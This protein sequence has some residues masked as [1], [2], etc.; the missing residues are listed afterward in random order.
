MAQRWMRGSMRHCSGTRRTGICVL[1]DA[2]TL[3]AVGPR[4]CGVSA[5]QHPL[6]DIGRPQVP[7][8]G[9]L[10]RPGRWVGG[11]PPYVCWLP[12]GG[13]T[14]GPGVWLPG[15]ESELHGGFD[16]ELRPYPYGGGA[17][18]RCAGRAAWGS[19][20]V[21]ADTQPRSPD[22][23]LTWPDGCGIYQDPSI[24]QRATLIEI[25]RRD[26]Q[27]LCPVMR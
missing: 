24:G 11:P 3:H 7:C 2:G 4:P 14:G 13:T 19:E 8:G 12:W 5:N 10:A 18:P 23:R 9:H 21:R 17:P 27:A 20:G 26:W 25:V 15:G 1:G 22:G 16:G 6:C